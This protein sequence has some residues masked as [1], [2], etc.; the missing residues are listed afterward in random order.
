MALLYELNSF[1]YRKGK[2]SKNILF[3]LQIFR[4]LL[5]LFTQ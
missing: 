2:I 1:Y 4:K 5:L 3:D